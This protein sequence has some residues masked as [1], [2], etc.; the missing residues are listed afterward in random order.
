MLNFIYW[1]ISAVLW[2][3]HKVF[4]LFMS[5]DWGVTWALSI[6]MLTFTV[7]ALLLKPTINSMRS[8]RKMQILQPKMQA[9]QEKYKNNPE[10]MMEETRRVQKEVGASPMK[11]CL[12]ML[13]QM[14]VFIGLFHVLRSFNRTGTGRGQ[15]GLSIEENYNTPNY[16]FGVEDVRSFLEAR[17]F[18]VP[19]SAYI[20][21]PED[22]YNAFGEGDFTRT[23]VIMVAAPFIL[24]IA[25]ATHLNGRFSV[26][27]QKERLA[28]GKQ[29]A[30]ANDQAQM[31]TD[32]MNKMMLYFMPLTILFTGF[33][34][35]IG[36]LCYMAGN[37]IWTFFQQRYVFG[38]M[39]AEEEAE[40]QERQ[41][42]AQATA[43]KV[44][45]KPKN[46][47]KQKKRKNN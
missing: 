13:V 17:L 46:P 18:G 2:F 25:V 12:P 36:L 28:S 4:G 27:R 39:D 31:T 24:L 8:M 40:E 15:L 11:G 16:I 1:P 20:S 44:G 22:M 42:K 29:K 26:Q 9:I 38:K 37:N 33:V 47:K 14:P 34:W 41:A 23:N 7:R 5:P 35:H 21:M 32:M 3:W 6:V 19:L 10:K 45:A 30:P 43:P